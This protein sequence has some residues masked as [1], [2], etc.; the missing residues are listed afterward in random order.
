MR[1]IDSIAPKKKTND[2]DNHTNTNG[3]GPSN[4]DNNTS[5]S[6]NYTNQRQ[7]ILYT[8]ISLCGIIARAKIGKGE[9]R[10]N[11]RIHGGH[12][13]KNHGSAGDD[14][15]AETMP[16]LLK[17]NFSYEASIGKN[18]NAISETTRGFSTSM[19]VFA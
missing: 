18:H 7:R 9:H 11:P 12:D 17:G 3:N 1:R 10:H 4:Y 8:V 5:I 14:A 6:D 15:T 2:N 16:A 13:M 19:Q